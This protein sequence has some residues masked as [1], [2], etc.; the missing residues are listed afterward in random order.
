MTDFCFSKVQGIIFDLDDTLVKTQLDFNFVKQHLGCPLSQDL[1]TYVDSLTC[2]SQRKE[3]Q[4]FILSYELQDAEQSRWLPNASDFVSQALAQ[5]L[6]LA[7][8][9]RNSVAATQRKLE[10]NN[11][12]ISRV[13]TRE[14]AP[15][16]PDP[17]AL[18]TLAG[19]W[20]LNTEDIAYIGDYIYDIEAAHNA[21]MQAWL[22]K[23]TDNKPYSEC[24]S[25]IP[26]DA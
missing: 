24:L 15:P 5:D 10:T 25:L 3:A 22:Y 4:D 23:F 7:I 16:K 14:D 8:V 6:P 17:T 13:I 19:E 26:K 2:L 11:I 9:T 20:Q 21:K 1:L 12:P 18:L